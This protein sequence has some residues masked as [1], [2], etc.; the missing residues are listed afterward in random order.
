VYFLTVDEHLVPPRELQVQR[1]NHVVDCIDCW[2]TLPPDV[3]T[4]AHLA[5]V[6]A[7]ILSI[8][9]SH[10]SKYTVWSSVMFTRTGE[11]TPATLGNISTQLTSLGAQQLYTSGSFFRERYLTSMG[12]T[13]GV[14]SAPISGIS[15]DIPDVNQIYLFGL[16]LQYT[17]A[18]AQAFMQGFY[19]PFQ[20]TSN[21][22]QIQHELDPLSI[23]AN[24]SYV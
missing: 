3:M 11:R 21:D 4:F 16:N 19:P 1:V 5:V 10:A 13:N 18:S 6:A 12:S 15:V 14:D 9:M 7:T 8:P 17:A 23:L 20:L 24:G 2:A 22:S